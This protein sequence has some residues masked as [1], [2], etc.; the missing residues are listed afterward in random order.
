MGTMMLSPKET[1]EA[2]IDI[3]VK[4]GRHTLHYSLSMGVLAGAM[5]ALAAVGSNVGTFN[6][7]GD[8][9]LLGVGKALQGVMFAGGLAMV[10][11]TGAE[12]F[13]GNVLLTLA[14][15][16]RRLS[17]RQ[18]ITNWW[19]VWLANFIG[20]LLVVIAVYGSGQFH[21]G[22]SM[23]GAM[24]VKAALGKINLSFVEAF[25]LGVLCNWLVCLAVWISF[26]AKSITGKVVGIFFPIWLFVVSGYEHC[27]A[28][29]Y[30]V[31]AGI[32][33][34]QDSSV[35]QALVSMGI[36]E[37]AVSSLTWKAFIVNNLLPVTLGNILGGAVLVAGIFWYAHCCSR[38]SM[39]L[40]A[41]SHNISIQR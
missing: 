17:F 11:T 20:A 23:L 19:K 14:C 26:S 39:R 25:L 21:F 12:L 35:M 15:L 32:M 29:M 4:K 6:L 30:Y 27:I 36:S 18:L 38:V 31:P 10:V 41:K 8:T 40:T 37:Q 16:E 34:S 28:N 24:T 13:T 2:V 9:S 7:L 1:V 22:Q 33:A 3:G 5:I